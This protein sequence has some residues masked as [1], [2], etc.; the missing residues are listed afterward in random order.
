MSPLLRDELRIAL[1]PEK[2]AMVRLGSGF[3]P[4]VLAKD[5]IACDAPLHDESPWSGALDSLERKLRTLEGG[6]IDVT[7]VLSDH[8]VRYVLVP[9]SDQVND[10]DEERAFV[11]H[12][13]TQTYGKDAQHWALRMSQNGYGRTQVASAIDQGLLDD[14]ERVANAHGFRLVS[15]QPHFMTVFNQWRRQ[16]LGAVV[17]FVV[18]EPGRLCVSQLQQGCWHILRTVKVGNDWQEALKKLLEREFL[19]SESGMERGTVY[20]YAPDVADETDLPGW[21]VHHL[22]ATPDGVLHNGIHSAMF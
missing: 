17:W 20:L 14:L 18:A 10:K 5:A 16:L 4:A 8:F 15:L 2:V 12:C 19:M 7:V 21:T 11:R 1:S 13:F 22:R 9:W 3:R 6:K